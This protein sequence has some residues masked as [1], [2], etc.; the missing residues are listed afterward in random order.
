MQTIAFEG[1]AVVLSANQCMTRK[2]LPKWIH[3][4]S[5]GVESAA[6][7]VGNGP[8]ESKTPSTTI[9]STVAKTEDSH[10]TK[11]PAS[12]PKVEEAGDGTNDLAASWTS[13]AMDNAVS[14]SGEAPLSKKQSSGRRASSI[15]KTFENHE[16]VLPAIRDASS[17][18]NQELPRTHAQDQDEFVSRGGSCIV[19]PI[20]S[21][22]AGPLWEVE[23]GGIL[24]AE[25]DFE[26]C[27]R[28]RLDLDVAGSYSR[29]D[30]FRLT[31]QGLDINPPP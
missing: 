26:D 23:D 14:E 13:E 19:D 30:A 12:L 24:V 3:D 7:P 1:R 18:S 9:D 16:V 20:R 21:T 31:V 4:P 17:D 29:N 6:T 15:A 11:P 25:V 5:Q 27:E 8:S 28:G 2:S 10:E 22:L